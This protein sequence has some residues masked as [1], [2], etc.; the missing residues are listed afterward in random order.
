MNRTIFAT[1]LLFLSTLALAQDPELLPFAVTQLPNIG[2][3][4][5]DAIKFLD[6]LVQFSERKEEN[7]LTL[8]EGNAGGGKIHIAFKLAN[9]K[10]IAG[11]IA[12]PDASQ[13]DL[14]ALKYAMLVRFMTNIIPEVNW[15]DPKQSELLGEAIAR[16]SSGQI[17]GL[18]KEVGEK[19]IFVIR[20]PQSGRIKFL[21]MNARIKME[22]LDIGRF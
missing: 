13:Q 14:S 22:H 15:N 2:V 21:V 3:E 11:L 17:P 7:G 1:A 19:L 10:V 20:D 6:R 5:P 8:L 9:E 18:S 12:V 16:L 4:K